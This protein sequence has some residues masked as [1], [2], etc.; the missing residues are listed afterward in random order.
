MFAVQSSDATAVQALIAQL[1]QGWNSKDAALFAQSFEDDADFVA[2]N[3][4]HIQGRAMIER[5]HQQLFT[6]LYH[7]STIELVVTH[8]RLLRADLALVHVQNH[9]QWQRGEQAGELRSTIACVI[10]K[11]DQRWAIASFQ[12][13]L[14]ERPS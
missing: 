13:T 11:S 1:A 6:T 3:G 5:A 2:I 7:N 10:A 9:N 8:M 12:N 4:M 14:I